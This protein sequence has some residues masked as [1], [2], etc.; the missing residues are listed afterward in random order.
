MTATESSNLTFGKFA[1]LIKFYLQLAIEAQ[2]QAESFHVKVKLRNYVE[3]MK[4]YIF[5]LVKPV[6]EPVSHAQPM[7]NRCQ[8]TKHTPDRLND[9]SKIIVLT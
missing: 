5:D 8:Y 7:P 1:S 3:L 2:R 6:L 9:L 4:S